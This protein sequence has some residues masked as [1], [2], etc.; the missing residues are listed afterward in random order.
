MLYYR[1]IVKCI[2]ILLAHLP[3][4]AHF[5]FEPVC[6]AEAESHRIHSEMNSGDSWWDTLN[7]LPAGT[8]IVP[9]ICPSDK[10]HLNKYSADQHALPLYLPIGNIRNNNCRS[11]KH[12]NR[13]LI[14]LIPC[15]PKGATN[16][17]EAWH[18]AGWNCAVS[19]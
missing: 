10:T 1:D 13:I 5:D 3:F 18:K 2:R 6:L 9:V 7:Q 4:Q 8:T 17:D 14:E 19:T 16:I 15:S 12:R 11:P